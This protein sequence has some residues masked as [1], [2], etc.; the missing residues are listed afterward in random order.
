VGAET[1]WVK[2]QTCHFEGDRAA[3]RQATQQHALN[4]L[5]VL[6]NQRSA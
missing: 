3:V 1:A 4:Q 6:L 2:V 5:L